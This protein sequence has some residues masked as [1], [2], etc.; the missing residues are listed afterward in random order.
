M[1]EGDTTSGVKLSRLARVALLV[2]TVLGVGIAVAA[3]LSTGS[4][5]SLRLG[6]RLHVVLIHFPVALLLLAAPLEI[7]ARYSGDSFWRRA[8]L[9]CLGLGAAAALVAAG[10]GWANAH[11]ETQGG[12][13]AEIVFWHRWCGV[14]VVALSLVALLVAHRDRA[15]TLYVLLLLATAGLTGWVGHLGG[16]LVFGE[17]YFEKAL[18]SPDPAPVSPASPAVTRDDSRSLV[19]YADV[20]PILEAHC[21]ECHGARKQKGRLRLDSLQ[22]IFAEREVPTVVPGKPDESELYYRVV[23]PVD[24]E[25][26]MPKDDAPLTHEQVRTIRNWIAGGAGE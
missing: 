12:A 23:L 6:G 5:S 13:L 4:F 22:W 17:D 9:E 15:R 14:G 24:D 1:S 3:E 2:G 21:T 19:A 20:R 7:A 10:T 26:F 18:R 8:G 25:D 11:F 16:S